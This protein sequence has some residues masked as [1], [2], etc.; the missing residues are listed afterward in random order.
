M[1]FHLKG[2]LV[3]AILIALIALVIWAP[4]KE[5]Q[6]GEM[7]EDVFGDFDGEWE[8]RFT[9]YSISSDW[10]ESFRQ[11]MHLI[12]VTSDSQAG[13]IVIFSPEGDTLSRDSL[14]HMRRGDSLYCLRIGEAGGREFNRG[15]WIDGQIVWRNQDIFGRTA[16]AYREFV[17]KGVWEIHGFSRTDRGDYLLQYGR[18]IRR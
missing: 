1:P 5:R 16:N 2:L 14:F 8:G 13:E 11:T 7:P 12:S 6:P 15:H 10:R 18:A 4:W 17:R 9:S 3:L